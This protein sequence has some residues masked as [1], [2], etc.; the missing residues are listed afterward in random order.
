MSDILGEEQR[1]K[2]RRSS[3]KK[4]RKLHRVLDPLGLCWSFLIFDRVTEGL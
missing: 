3:Y 4:K 2:D 1:R